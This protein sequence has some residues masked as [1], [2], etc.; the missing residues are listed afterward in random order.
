MFT[1]KERGHVFTPKDRGHVFRSKEG[2]HL[3]TIKDGGHVFTF[4]DVLRVVVYLTANFR[5]RVSPQVGQV[6]SIVGV[7]MSVG[8]ICAEQRTFKE[9]LIKY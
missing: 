3:F 1:L 2:G 8:Y 9:Q 7:N 6:S 4:K 5:S